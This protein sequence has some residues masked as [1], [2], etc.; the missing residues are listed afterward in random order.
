MS[1]SEFS[2]LHGVL[3]QPS[4]ST[5]SN[6]I[7]VREKMFFSSKQFSYT[8]Q[9]INVLIAK[10]IPLRFRC[11]SAQGSFAKAWAGTRLRR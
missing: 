11:L 4:A 5:R 8:S 3:Q 2:S 1:F 7:G 9:C 10:I 6:L